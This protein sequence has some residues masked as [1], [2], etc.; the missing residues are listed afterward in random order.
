LFDAS[1]L[2]YHYHFTSATDVTLGSSVAVTGQLCTAWAQMEL[3]ANDVE[4]IGT[5]DPVVSNHVN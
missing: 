1:A 3:Q 5:C 4:V 2:I